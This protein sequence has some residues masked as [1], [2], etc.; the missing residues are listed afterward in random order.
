MQAHGRDNHGRFAQGNPGGPGR[1]PTAKERGYLEA[2]TAV[3]TLDEWRGICRRAVK[4]AKAGDARARDWLS[5][6]LVGE[7]HSLPNVPT[8]DEPTPLANASTEAILEART[9]FARLR[10]SGNGNGN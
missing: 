6:Y 9:V 5:K 8:P 4:D 1:P 3:C 7:P 2:L 10:E